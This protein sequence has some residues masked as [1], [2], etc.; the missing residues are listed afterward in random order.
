MIICTACGNHNE[1]DDEFCGSCGKFLEWVG[2]KVE[3][4]PPPEP[5]P[6]P[7]PEPARAG[8]IERVK[9]AVGIEEGRAEATTTDL[10]PSPSEGVGVGPA[11]LSD[12]PASNGPATPD[13]SV[14]PAVTGP[15]AQAEPDAA[16]AERDAVAAQAAAAE[17]Q[18]AERQAAEAAAQAERDAAE[19]AIR[20]AQEAEQARRAAEEAAVRAE[21]E[22]AAATEAQRAA[23]AAAEEQARRQAEEAAAAAEAERQAR[24]AADALQRAQAEAEAEQQRADAERARA[25]DAARQQAE[26]EA[27]REAEEAAAAARARQEAEA[28]AARAAVEA[29]AADEERRRREEAEAHAAQAEAAEAE[30]ARQEAEAAA[31]AEQAR[32]QAEEESRRKAEEARQKEEEAKAE[33]ARRAAA[34]LAK[35]KSVTPTAPA[36]APPPGRRPSLAGPHT[37]PSAAPDET[38]AVPTP[39]PAMTGAQAEAA[40]P[41]RPQSHTPTAQQPTTAKRPPRPA[42]KQKAAEQAIKPGDLVCGQCGTGNDPGR[43]FCRKCGNSLAEAAPA[44]K[45]PWYK[46]IFSRT[47]KATKAGEG[48]RGQTQAK[49]LARS[50]QTAGWKAN[51]ALGLARR[52][53]LML[54]LVGVAVPFAV[55]SLRSTVLSKGGDGLRWAKGVINPS[56]ETV[57]PLNAVASSETPDHPAR[58]AIDL[59]SNTYWSEAAPGEGIG[60]WVAVEFDGTVDLAKVIVTPGATEPADQFLAQPRPKELRL[61]FDD[62]QPGPD[63]RPPI[64]PQ[65]IALRDEPTDQSFGLSGVTQVRKVTFFIVSVYKGQ[66]G[67]NTSVAELEFRRKG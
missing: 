19:R 61:V 7:E 3:E 40:A 54:L 59:G 8:L 17:R 9:A 48:K 43:K 28:A 44:A 49:Q 53:M 4:P 58:L 52:G 34:L 33:A 22:A 47:P 31:A 32:R 12:A 20:E 35:P 62:G 26:A 38:E 29:A 60:E 66:S 30:R 21:Q 41:A 65:T 1:D 24:E 50:A 2:E 5:E 27:R 16:Q 36:A 63:G 13:P 23:A 42:P 55:P 56:F 57:N 67:E 45:L 25:A 15:D 14:S 39:A 10:A 64:E 37:P 11:A 51:R 18:A 6:E 46:R